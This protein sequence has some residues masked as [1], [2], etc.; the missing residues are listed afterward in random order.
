MHHVAFQVENVDATLAG[1]ERAGTKLID[2]VGRPGAR[3]R[4][5]GFAHPTGFQGV[6]VEFVEAP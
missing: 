5:V 6:L 2:H 4:R 1:L 3:G